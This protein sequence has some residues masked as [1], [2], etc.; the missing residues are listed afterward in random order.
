LGH[1]RLRGI[2][3]HRRDLLMIV[4]EDVGN[5]GN[6]FT[7]LDPGPVWAITGLFAEIDQI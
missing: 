4:P 2:V 7:Q 1:L 5:S 3:Q 6:V